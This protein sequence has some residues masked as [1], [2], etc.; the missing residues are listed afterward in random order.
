MSTIRLTK[1]L[2]SIAT[3]T[4]LIRELGE[5]IKVQF[6]DLQKVKGKVELIKELLVSIEERIAESRIIVN[7]DELFMQIYTD[8]FGPVSDLEKSYLVEIVSYLYSTGVVVPRS[9]LRKFLDC[10]LRLFE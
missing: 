1:S 8:V 9:K 5:F 2:R 3:Q 7:K 10:I 4:Q 6:P